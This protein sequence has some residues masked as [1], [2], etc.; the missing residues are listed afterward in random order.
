MTEFMYWVLIASWQMW[1][2]VLPIESKDMP[3][4]WA[5]LCNSCETRKYIVSENTLRYGKSE[6]LRLTAYHE[7]CHVKLGHNVEYFDDH[8]HWSA[9]REVDACL[10]EFLGI[11]SGEQQKMQSAA[12]AWYYGE[13]KE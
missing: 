4:L 12:V 5:E 3:A 2:P 13:G 9:E 7:V 8:P 10:E 1:V 6:F 11:S